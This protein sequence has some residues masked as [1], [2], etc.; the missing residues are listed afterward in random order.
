MGVPLSFASRTTKAE[1]A[2]ILEA[3]PIQDLRSFDSFTTFPVEIVPVIRF[4][5]PSHLSDESDEGGREALT[6]RSCFPR[7]ATP[8][9]P[10]ELKR[11][12]HRPCPYPSI[13]DRPE[14]KSW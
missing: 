10:S 8:F 1:E 7:Q 5:V 4:V 9:F 14:R 12:I 2:S 6:P 3:V 11:P 13:M